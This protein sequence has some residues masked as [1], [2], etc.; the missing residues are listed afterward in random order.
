LFFVRSHFN[1]PKIDAAS[2]HLTIGGEVRQEISFSFEE[3]KKL[4]A[5]TVMA[6]IECAGNGRANLV[7]KVKGL[8]W[9]QGVLAMQIGRAC[10]Y[11]FCWTKLVLNPGLSN[12]F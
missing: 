1:I 10:R 2:W 11:P 3:I 7:P 8:P 9:E 4:P 6:T 5:K 12:L